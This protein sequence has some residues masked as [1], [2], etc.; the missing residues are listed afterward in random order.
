[1]ITVTAPTG[2]IGAQVVDR[3]LD[4]G[5]PV[6]VV[7]RDPARLPSRVREAVDVIEGSHADADVIAAAFD[8]TEAL[9]WLVPPNPQAESVEAAYVDFTK[10]ACAALPGTGITRVVGISALGRGTPMAPYAGFVTGALA[11]DDMLA[12]TGVPYRALVLP[13]FMDNLLRQRAAIAERGMF[14]GPISGDR[15]LP[16]CATRDIAA[17]AVRLLTDPSWS[18]IGS[19]PVLG[20]QDLSF[21]DMAA[22]MSD[23]LGRPVRF[24]QIDGEAYAATMRSHGM[25]AAMAQGMLDM[26][27]AKDGGLD[28][29]QPRTPESSSPTTFRQWCLDVLKPALDQ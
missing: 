14:F 22:V 20:P 8:G 19:V 12:D 29:A 1:M 4:H 17:A 10:P 28:N 3:L 25:S 9:F 21:E 6:R 24:Q 11:V 23:V 2:T 27:V 26:A 13:S 5:A 16:T 15:A 18:G 7:V